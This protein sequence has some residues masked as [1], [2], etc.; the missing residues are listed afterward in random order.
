MKNTPNLDELLL[1]PDFPRNFNFSEAV[2]DLPSEQYPQWLDLK[3]RWGFYVQQKFHHLASS[4]ESDLQGQMKEL[5]DG[6]IKIV[7]EMREF[8]SSYLS[9]H[10]SKLALIEKNNLG[11]T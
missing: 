4:S 5:V 7:S 6:E 11:S 9:E 10:P 2:K 1:D 8:L 3:N